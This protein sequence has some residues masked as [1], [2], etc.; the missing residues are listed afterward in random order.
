MDAGGILQ[1]SPSARGSRVTAIQLITALSLSGQP[2]GPDET[3]CRRVGCLTRRECWSSPINRRRSAG[4]SPLT[5]P[6]GSRPCSPIG[7]RRR[8][9]RQEGR[10]RQYHPSPE[11]RDLPEN[12]ISPAGLFD[13]RSRRLLMGSSTAEDPYNSPSWSSSMSRS[14]R[15]NGAG[16]AAAPR[17]PRIG[18]QVCWTCSV[19]YLRANPTLEEGKP[20]VDMEDAVGLDSGHPP[21]RRQI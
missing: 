16:V 12:S 20:G 9:H 17:L 4:S 14:M 13:P 19:Q 1:R 6:S 8:R 21:P 15:Q 7:R 3:L 18:E 10:Y 5:S 11:R 2:G